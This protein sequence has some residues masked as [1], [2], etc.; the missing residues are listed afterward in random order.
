MEPPQLQ[1]YRWR[2][3]GGEGSSAVRGQGL[4]RD[5]Q[6]QRRR[7]PTLNAKTPCRPRPDSALYSRDR[8]EG[9]RPR[10]RGPKDTRRRGGRPR[11]HVRGGPG[12]PW[13]SRGPGDRPPPSPALGG[14]EGTHLCEVRWVVEGHCGPGRALC[15]RVV[16]GSLR[17]Q[18]A[19]VSETT[20]HSA[21]R[22]VYDTHAISEQGFTT[23]SNKPQKQKA[24][25]SWSTGFNC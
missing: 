18:R 21:L 20:A 13:Q 23:L 9:K 5:G 14:S 24:E 2:G 8:K 4:H 10:T 7:A 15:G 16:A 22:S 25:T 12:A 1:V 6:G 19:H 17:A 11:P 3:S